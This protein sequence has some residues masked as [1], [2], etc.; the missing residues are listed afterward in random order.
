MR[1]LTSI[2]I[3][4]AL[5]GRSFAQDFPSPEEPR[6]SPPAPPPLELTQPRLT[7]RRTK[8]AAIVLGAAG[9]LLTVTGG[10]LIG[11]HNQSDA[12]DDAGFVFTGV[13]VATALAGL[14][15]G[16]SVA[17]HE[18]GLRQLA[19]VRNSSIADGLR[20]LDAA[21]ARARVREHVG[22][23][24]FALGAAFAIAGTAMVIPS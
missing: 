22:I 23:A 1:V 18:A 17:G 10:L 9:A 5:A 12:A 21:D 13:G 6:W 8:T 7:I 20:F 19:L 14:Y 15:T 11:L 24:L 4:L 2:V 16:V 3:C